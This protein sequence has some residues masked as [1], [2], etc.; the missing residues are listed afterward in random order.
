[1]PLYEFYCDRCGKKIEELCRSGV[2]AIQC[3]S[4]GGEARKLIS[5]FRKGRGSS[6]GG[7]SSGGCSG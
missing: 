2:T 7:A 4:C 3:V 1:M 5:A 6:G